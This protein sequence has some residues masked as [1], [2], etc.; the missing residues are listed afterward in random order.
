MSVRDEGGFTLV[1][2]LVAMTVGLILMA[3]VV[4]IFVSGT[5]TAADANAR[6]AAQQNGRLALDRL[7]FEARCAT[8]ATLAGGGSGVSLVLPSWCVH[9]TGNVCWG[10]A[11]GTLTRYAS[12]TCTGSGQRY[13]SGI[14]SATPFSLAVATGDLPRLLVALTVNTTNRSSDALTLDDTITLRNAA[15]S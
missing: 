6:I 8:S 5:R 4:N 9:G 13:V 11:S 15:R 3:G 12:S 10:V 14:T 1:E 7:E 2:L